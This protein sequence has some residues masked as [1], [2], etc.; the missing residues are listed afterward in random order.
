MTALRAR[1]NVLAVA[2]V[3]LCGQAHVAEAPR[4]I[5]SEAIEAALGKSREAP[6][7]MKTRGLRVQARSEEARGE[8]TGGAVD[9]QVSF[10]LNSAAILPE[11]Q[12]Q[13]REL[14]SALKSP[15]LTGKPF[16]LAGHTD[17]TGNP[18]RNRELSL[19]RATAVRDYLQGAGVDAAGLS[20]AGYGSDRP[21]AGKDPKAAENRRVEVRNL[22]VSP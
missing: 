19:A 22:G 2:A 11:A 1:L 3:F 5:S 15:G 6:T 21:L 18:Q 8:E 10:A 12:Q 9:L 7:E 4:V 17:S 16:V 14:A 20:V 13:L